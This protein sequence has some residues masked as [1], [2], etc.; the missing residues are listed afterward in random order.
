LGWIL[1]LNPWDVKNAEI[2]V[3]NRLQVIK[4]V[5]NLDVAASTGDYR[6]ERDLACGSDSRNG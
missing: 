1:E 4:H 3:W 5:E 6:F 2:D